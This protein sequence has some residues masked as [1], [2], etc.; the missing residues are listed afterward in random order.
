MAIASISTII[1]GK[2]K[3]GNGTKLMVGPAPADIPA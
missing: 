3:Q 2:A 1:P